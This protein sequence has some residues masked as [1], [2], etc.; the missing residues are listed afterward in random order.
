MVTAP[1]VQ[2]RTPAERRPRG[3]EK[4][5]RAGP[6]PEFLC[7]YSAPP[8]LPDGNAPEPLRVPC[9]AFRARGKVL[10]GERISHPLCVPASRCSILISYSSGSE[11]GLH[12]P[13]RLCPE[14]HGTLPSTPGQGVSPGLGCPPPALLPLTLGPNHE[15]APRGAEPA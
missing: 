4:Y 6:N 3:S 2:T 5:A 14:H 7:T 15:W 11:T 10:K 13:R 1:V 12:V 8:Q 9:T